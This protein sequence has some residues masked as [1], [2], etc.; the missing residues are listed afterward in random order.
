MASPLNL[1]ELFEAARGFGIFDF[2]LPF[3]LAFALFY[4][5]LYKAKIFGEE[6]R[7]RKLNLVIS[8]I[9]SL[10][11]IGYTPVGVTL[12]QLL[13]GLFGGTLI[14]VVTILAALIILF[15]LIPL[16]G[17]KL[18]TR[19]QK[20]IGV[21]AVIAI[22]L[23]VGIFIS[24][25]GAMLFPGLQLPGVEL[26]SAPLPVLPEIGLTSTDIAIIVMFI[27]T[28]GIVWWLFTEKST[29]ST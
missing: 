16:F 7:G 23:A 29:K 25:G 10:F 24:S 11:V 27:L 15:M 17:V 18:D 2:Y 1:P 20:I 14:V 19:P 3:I 4:G 12:S 6:K 22:I 21:F 13:T 8:L 26:P 9:L 5:L 28:L